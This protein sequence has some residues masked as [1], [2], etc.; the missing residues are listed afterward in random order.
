VKRVLDE[1]ERAPAG[2]EWVRIDA[3]ASLLL[4]V[5]VAQSRAQDQQKCREQED[6]RRRET[7][8]RQEDERIVQ[9]KREKE[10]GAKRAKMNRKAVRAKPRPGWHRVLTKLADA[11]KELDDPQSL[12]RSAD[13]D[14]NKRRHRILERLLALGPDRRIAMP[15]RWRMAVE[16]LEAALPHFAAPIRALRNALAL[17]EATDTA[18]RVP[19]Q[20]LLGPPGV[21]KTFYSH[22]VAELFGSAHASVPFD[23]PSAGAQLRGSDKYW[24]NT[25][26]GVLFSLICLGEFANPVVLLDEMDKAC[27]GSTSRELNPLAQLHGALE[28][29]TAQ[30][31]LD[32]S[33]DVEFDASLAVYVGTANSLRGLGAPIVSRMQVFVIEPPSKWQ[34]IDIAT[35][36]SRN[37]LQRLRLQ[38]R[39]DFE[40]Q[41]LC[42]LAHLSPR[43]MVRAAEQSVAAAVASGRSRIGEADLWKE[44]GDA[45]E[46]KFH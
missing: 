46:A 45:A 13:M 39:V 26:P 15:A 31:L 38:G 29:E 18:P 14:L 20:L 40:R 7:L 27:A 3:D 44:L 2:F 35:Q 30:R 5:E 11:A 36:I 42:L 12:E 1:M 23:Q 41:A 6:D 34:A 17:A 32:I 28:R 24:S 4:P 8:R 37:V 19:P 25:E 10:A 9:A 21:G 16:E 43:H 33:V 22:R